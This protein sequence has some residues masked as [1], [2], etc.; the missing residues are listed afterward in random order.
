MGNMHDAAQQ[1]EALVLVVEDESLMRMHAVIMIEE[2][3]YNVVEA[4]NAD[5]A[6]AIL[7]SREDIRVVVTDIEMPGSMDGI[8]LARAIRDR[9]PPV[10][11][12]VTSGRYRVRS[13][14]LPTR[15]KFMP[16]PYTPDLLVTAIR[17]LHR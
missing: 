4:C 6:I 5:A 13:D 7:E 14:E 3:G 15:A 10:E 16:K 17:T 2:A 1:S 12:I 11:L 9:W 8:K